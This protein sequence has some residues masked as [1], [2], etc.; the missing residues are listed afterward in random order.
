MKLV[1]LA[2]S[3]LG[4]DFT[5]DNTVP[6]RVSC[7]FAITTLLHEFDPDI[8]ITAGTY[9]HWRWLQNSTKFVRVFEPQA[10]DIVISPTGT[11]SDPAHRLP[12][13]HTGIY[14]TNNTIASNDSATGLF[15]QNYTRESWRALFHY[16]GRYSVYLYRYAPL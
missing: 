3:K 14:L 12:N 2:K 9:G 10:G 15:K 13:G 6:D 5:D 16:Y 11:S 1:D 8:P 4:T 7:A